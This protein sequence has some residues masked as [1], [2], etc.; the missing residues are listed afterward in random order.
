LIDYV[1]VA[2]LESCDQH[3]LPPP[4]SLV[5]LVRERLGGA[6]VA[7]H[8]QSLIDQRRVRAVWLAHQALASGDQISMR[9]IAKTIGVEA[10]TVSR[11]FGRGELRR[12]AEKIQKWFLKPNE[13]TRKT[14]R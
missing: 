3:G 6:N 11:W 13:L 9:Q 10:S 5:V 14:K 1:L 7:R 2:M 8:K 12:E 4:P